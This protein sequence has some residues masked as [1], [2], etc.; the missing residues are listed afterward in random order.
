MNSPFTLLGIFAPVLTF[1]LLEK[2][3]KL[4]TKLIKQFKTGRRYKLTIFAI[5]FAPF[6]IHAWFIFFRDASFNL[7]LYSILFLYHY[8]MYIPEELR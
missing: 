1:F 5:T 8:L 2:L 3:F 6:L 4:K 7:S